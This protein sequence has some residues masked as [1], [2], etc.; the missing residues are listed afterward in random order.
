MRAQEGHDGPADGEAHDLA[1]LGGG[2]G[3]RLAEN[4][5]LALQDIRVHRGP[6]RRERG[7]DHRHHDEQYDQR[8]HGNPGQ[9]HDEDQ[10]AAQEVTGDHHG[11]AREPVGQAAQRDPADEQR[12]DARHECHRGQQRRARSGVHQHGQGD[13][14]QLVPGHGGKLRRP[15]GA[16]LADGENVTEPNFRGLFGGLAPSRRACS[17]VTLRVLPVCSLT[18]H[19]CVNHRSLQQAGLSL[20]HHRR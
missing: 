1:E 20:P 5:P 17:Y 4:V 19:H 8:P 3:D 13:T 10:Q 11:P 14:G 6:G 12:Q 9:R 18:S 16:E 7:T 15:Q 2:L